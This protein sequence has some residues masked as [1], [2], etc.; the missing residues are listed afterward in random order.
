M[1]VRIDP[2][3]LLSDEIR[4]ADGALREVTRQQNRNSRKDY[5][6]LA[7]L[8]AERVKRLDAELVEMQPTSA[9]GSAELL[10]VCADRLSFTQSRYIRRLHAVA[11]SLSAGQCTSADLIWL[12]AVEVAAREGMLD[13]VGVG[14]APLL[15]SAITGASR[16]V[17]VSDSA[18]LSRDNPAWRT[19]LSMPAA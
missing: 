8:L 6:C 16:P 15:R 7:N 14:V 11:D 19:V 1:R 17:V 4:S 18:C 12:R 2:V 3:L 10:R 13:S 9:A 5:S